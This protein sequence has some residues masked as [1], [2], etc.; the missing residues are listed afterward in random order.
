MNV[1]PKQEI[2]VLYLKYY[3]YMIIETWTIFSFPIIIQLDTY[4]PIT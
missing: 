4:L 1:R 3:I 2:I